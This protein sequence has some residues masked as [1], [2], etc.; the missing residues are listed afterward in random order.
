ML[1]ILIGLAGGILIGA[2]GAGAGLLVTPVLILA[3]YRPMVAVGA[4]MG[5]L[6]VSKAVGALELRSLG[7]RPER[8]GWLVIGGGVAGAIL[9]SLL[10]TRLMGL[11]LVSDSHLRIAIGIVLLLSAAAAT[12]AS[13]RDDRPAS[14][15]RLTN[16]PLLFGVGFIV[17]VI[18]SITSAGSG[19]LLV[20]LL[21]VGQSARI[22]QLVATSSVFG[23]IVG[24]LSLG[25]HW[26]LFSL[27][28]PLLGLLLA[29][30]IP[31]VVAGAYLS[32]RI[33]RTFLVWAVHMLG[34]S[35]GAALLVV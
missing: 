21:L 14:A 9:G 22:P 31:G 34:I 6:L 3:G 35:F 11:N 30:L 27:D 5:T 19:G 8:S 2:T 16:A 32:R 23:S 28:L 4:G 33:S 10:A 17:A 24:A 29:G 12:W 25:L 15:A 13:G 26:S 20:P 7:A 1:E 18:V